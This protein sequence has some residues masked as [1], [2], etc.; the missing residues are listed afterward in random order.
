M[1]KLLIYATGR[2]LEYY[3]QRAIEQILK[4]AREDDFRFHSLVIA[5]VQSDPFRMR[6][7]KE[8]E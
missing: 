7:G 1:E 3:D 5:I 4:Q 6:S 2:S 8:Q